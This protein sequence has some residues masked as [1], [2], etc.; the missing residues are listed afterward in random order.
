MH[1]FD[2]KCAKSIEK[3]KDK[4]GLKPQKDTHTHESCMF[5]YFSR[6]HI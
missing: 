1:L 3:Q 6:Y 2:E 5:T 4:Y